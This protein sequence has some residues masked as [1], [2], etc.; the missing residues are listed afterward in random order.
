MLL[1]IA[2]LFSILKKF[3]SLN[4]RGLD[5]CGEGIIKA[6]VLFGL[7]KRKGRHSDN[8]KA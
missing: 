4:V 1:W 3:V 5:N 6:V 8:S 2:R 7:Q